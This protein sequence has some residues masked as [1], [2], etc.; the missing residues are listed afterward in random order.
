MPINPIGL[1][2]GF[3]ARRSD[4]QAAIQEIDAAR[5]N[6]KLPSLN[7][8]DYRFAVGRPGGIPASLPVTVTYKPDSPEAVE[9]GTYR[10]GL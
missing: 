3:V 8:T 10:V 7:P 5:Q 1:L 9:L 6:A 4:A 2:P